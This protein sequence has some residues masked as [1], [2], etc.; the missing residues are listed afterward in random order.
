MPIIINTP[1]SNEKAYLKALQ[2][3]VAHYK[4]TLIPGS[5]A[6]NSFIFGHS[7][8]YTNVAGQY[9]DV[10]ENLNRSKRM[11]RWW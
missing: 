1:G 10:F 4:G 11:M 8:Y 5:E 2:N 3:G 6:G 9:K 7:S